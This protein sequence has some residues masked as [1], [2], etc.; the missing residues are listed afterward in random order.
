MYLLSFGE[1][2]I[3]GGCKFDLTSDGS[4]LA[5]RQSDPMVY[6]TKARRRCRNFLMNYSTQTI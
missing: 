6:D 4:S 3:K 5:E 2:L 1:I